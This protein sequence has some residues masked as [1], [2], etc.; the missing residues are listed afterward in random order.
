MEKL[1]AECMKAI[2]VTVF[3]GVSGALNKINAIVRENKMENM[4]RLERRNTFR[5]QHQLR[6]NN[7]CLN[8]TSDKQQ[9]V[10][11][12]K[13]ADRRRTAMLSPKLLKPVS[14]KKS[15]HVVKDVKKTELVFPNKM[16]EKPIGIKCNSPKGAPRVVLKSVKDV[17][18]SFLPIKQVLD[19]QIVKKKRQQLLRMDRVEYGT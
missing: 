16:V 8:D 11:E 17:G 1:D 5:R 19:I 15:V 14:P 7:S 12:R 6:L 18:S 2:F 10:L 3:S 13:V 4:K 9:K